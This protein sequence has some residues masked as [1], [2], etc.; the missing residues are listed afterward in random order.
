MSE[1]EIIFTKQEINRA[2]K[3]LA[4]EVMVDYEGKNPLLIGV[5]K[6]ALVFMADLI[7]LLD[8]PIDVEFVTLSSYGQGAKETSG[9]VT[10][11]K[12]LN[13]S[14]GGR[15]VLLVDDIV[16][17]GITLNYLLSL[18]RRKNPNSL[19]ACVMFDKPAK[20]K[21]S[22]KIDYT[23]LTCQDYFVVG[24]GLDYCEKYRNLPELYHL[25]D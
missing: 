7:R 10:M 12:G 23:G 19:R 5:L 9:K 20:R 17:S 15:D 25:V 1:L 13:T 8:M 6:G 16:D 18:V 3:R 22:V 14:I 11:I 2:V 4:E 24:Y 21:V